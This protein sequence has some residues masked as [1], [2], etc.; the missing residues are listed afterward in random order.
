M[1]KIILSGLF[2]FFLLLSTSELYAQFDLPYKLSTEGLKPSSFL[3]NDKP[4]SFKLDS[5]MYRSRIYMPLSYK[6]NELKPE[7]QKEYPFVNLGNLYYKGKPGTDFKTLLDN[8]EIKY[9]GYRWKFT[10]DHGYFGPALRPTS[11]RTIRKCI[12]Q[13]AL[14]PWQN[15]PQS[16]YSAYKSLYL[17]TTYVYPNE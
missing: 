11:G 17:I 5:I 16:K 9:E 8:A 13:D 2:L 6:I 3:L 10:F 1:S 7:Y 14:Y 15:A 12:Y 4:A